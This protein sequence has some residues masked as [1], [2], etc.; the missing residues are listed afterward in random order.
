MGI[1]LAD[2]L[3]ANAPYIDM[4]ELCTKNKDSLDI[5]ALENLIKA[6]ALIPLDRENRCQV[7]SCSRARKNPILT[8]S[9]EPGDVSL[10]YTLP[11]E[12]KII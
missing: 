10:D 2:E 11:K 1:G 9:F 8:Y 4:V 5:R 7:S 3:H 12:V 6:G